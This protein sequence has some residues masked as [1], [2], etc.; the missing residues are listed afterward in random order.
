LIGLGYVAIYSGHP[1]KIPA[2]D[3]R[4]RTERRVYVDLPV[5]VRR[6]LCNCVKGGDSASRRPVGIV[7]EI[8]FSAET[9]LA[10]DW[11]KVHRRNPPCYQRTH[12]Q[13]LLGRLSKIRAQR[14]R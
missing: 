9:R 12:E 10:K 13:I 14:G 2:R 11:T 7:E 1:G 6:D 3:D 8:N 4:R 5:G